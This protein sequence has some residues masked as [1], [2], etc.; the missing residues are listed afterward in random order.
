MWPDFNFPVGARTPATLSSKRHIRPAQA[1]IMNTLIR[2]NP[3]NEM[4]EIQNRLSSFFGKSLGSN[5][6][7]KL[8]LA[9]WAPLVD[10]IEHKKEYLIKAELPDVKK[11]DVKVHVEN[12]MLTISGER[13]FEKEEEGKK[14]HRVER[15]YGSFERTFTLPDACDAD[16]MAAK[17]SN[18][19]LTL[20]IPKNEK[21][22]PKAIDVKVD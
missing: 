20:H 17:Y 16:K 4:N 8:A 9:D 21:A 1:N 15:S 12:G 11:E 6:D 5:G 13:H 22:I 14:Y 10:V 18:G 7:G 19:M 3:V 2:W